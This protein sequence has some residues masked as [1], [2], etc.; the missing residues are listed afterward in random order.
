VS[1]GV[2]YRALW[3]HAAGARGRFVLAMAM[4]GASQL[5]KLAMPWMAAQAIN[6]LQAGGAGSLARAGAWIGGIVGTMMGVWLLHGPGRVIE[7]N[8]GLRVRRSLA[9]AL[10]GR[11]AAAPLAWHERQHSGELQH[12]L[13]QASGAL[14]DFTQNQFIYLQNLINLCGPLVALMLLS[15]LTGGI[16]LGGYVAIGAAIVG[17]DGALMR[18][19]GRENA[20]ERRYTARLLDCVGNVGSLLALKLQPAARRLL[21]QRVAEAQAPMRR[22]IVLNEWKWCAVD[23][24][25]VS[26][27]WGLVAAYAWQAHAGAAAVML[28]SLFMVYQ[29]AQQAAG[30]VGA[31]ASHYQ[32]FSRVKADYA[33]AAPLWQAPVLVEAAAAADAPRWR[34]LAIEQLTYRHAGGDD[35]RGGVRD[36]TLQLRRGERIALVGGSG[37]GKSTL[38]RVLAGLYEAQGGRVHGDDGRV[39]GRAELAAQA[40]LIPQEAEV[41]EASLRENLAFG[42]PVDEAVLVQA[43]HAS[44]FDRV[45]A[46]L[47]QGLDTAAGERGANFSG[48]QRQ[49]LALARGVLAARGSA[50]LLLDE[51]TSALDPLTERLVHERL[52]DAFAGACIV[53]SVHRMELLAHYDRVAFMA[54]GRLLDVGRVAEVAARQ[55]AFARMTQGI[56]GLGEGGVTVPPPA[57]CDGAAAAVPAHAEVALAA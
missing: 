54:N 23:L 7:R 14:N 21:D 17:F 24:L 15:W 36:V 30:V 29:Y 9:D 33:S 18:L 56:A 10:Y 42:E 53:A 11:L 39:F 34:R 27:S 31:M 35:D 45:L 13:Q 20:A 38:L 1:L 47:P 40:T 8:V 12:R 37:S 52:H 49:R 46:D 3:R 57:A 16:A 41:F 2:L 48:G 5:L 32:N 44:A 50:L 26:L 55:P 22:S 4:L 51:P 25:T 19:A 43:L 6:T 28:G